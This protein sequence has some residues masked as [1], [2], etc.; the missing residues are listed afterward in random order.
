MALL[1]GDNVY[2]RIRQNFQRADEIYNSGLF[3]FRDEKGRA[4]PPDTLT[5]TLQIDDKP[6]KDIIANLYYPESPYEF[7][8]LPAIFWDRFTSS[9]LA[10]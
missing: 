10:R 7:S 3:H 4:E 1:N 2:K 6:I 8:V 9:F 5:L